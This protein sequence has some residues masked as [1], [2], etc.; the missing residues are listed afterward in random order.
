MQDKLVA[1]G[2]LMTSGV[3]GA[4]WLEIASDAATLIATVV[5]GGLT[6]WYTWERAMKLRKERTNDKGKK[7]KG[8][9]NS[10]SGNAGG[11]GDSHRR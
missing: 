1:V 7:D 11:V 2:V 5:I 8:P 9:K 10:G 6:A 4:S 3:V